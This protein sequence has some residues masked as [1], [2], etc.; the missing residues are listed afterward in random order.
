MVEEAFHLPKGSVGIVGFDVEKPNVEAQ[1][2]NKAQMSNL[3]YKIY[4]N[5]LTFGF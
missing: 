1:S 5:C 2:S 4:E 3:K